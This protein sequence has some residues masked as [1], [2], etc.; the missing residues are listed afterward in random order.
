[1]GVRSYPTE[2]LKQQPL[3]VQKTLQ[4]WVEVEADTGHGVHVFSVDVHEDGSVTFHEYAV[5]EQGDRYVDPQDRSRAAVAPPR[6][7]V[8]TRPFPVA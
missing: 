6:R 7:V 5:N 1:M 3:E 8:P 4:E 2:W